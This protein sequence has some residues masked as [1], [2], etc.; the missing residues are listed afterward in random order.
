VRALQFCKKRV[1]AG[2]RLLGG[3]DCLTVHALW[4]CLLLGTNINSLYLPLSSE[5]RSSWPQSWIAG[6]LHDGWKGSVNE[7]CKRVWTLVLGIHTSLLR[8]EVHGIR[9]AMRW[10][11][12][13]RRAPSPVGLGVQVYPRRGHRLNQGCHCRNPS[14]MV[15][16]PR[17]L[18]SI[19][20]LSLFLFPGPPGNPIQEHHRRQTARE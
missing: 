6:Y 16:I 9:L 14:K 20:S 11:K 4:S 2:F 3:L 12:T 19:I 7:H 15:L 17:T 8:L 18:K 10:T 1:L 13:I 5:I